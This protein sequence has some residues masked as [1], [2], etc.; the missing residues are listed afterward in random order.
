[1]DKQERNKMHSE[2]NCI[3]MQ[4]GHWLDRNTFETCAFEHKGCLNHVFTLQL[5][6]QGQGLGSE[7]Q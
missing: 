5:S 1:M 4:H 3:L 2:A 6:F 7:G